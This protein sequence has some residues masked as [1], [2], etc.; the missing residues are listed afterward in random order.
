MRS[1]LKNLVGSLN[2]EPMSLE[3]SQELHR[4]NLST[5]YILPLL[6]LNKFKFGGDSNF[7]DSYLTLNHQQIVVQVAEV[8]F[9]EQRLELHPAFHSKLVREGKQYLLYTIPTEFNQDVNFYV[10][11]LYSKFSKE[12]KTL[13][14]IYSGLPYK[15]RIDA[16]IFTDPKLLALEKSDILKNF[17]VNFLW[18]NNRDS[19]ITDDAEL[20]SIPNKHKAF[21]DL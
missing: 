11:G 14:Q 9:L 4:E 12:A 15:E 20:L 1:S 2:E 6:K 3:I 17:W 7:V 21:I 16:V 19:V 8:A 13:I 18:D 5:F 10:S